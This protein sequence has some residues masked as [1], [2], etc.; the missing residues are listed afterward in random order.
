MVRTHQSQVVFWG[1][2]LNKMGLLLCFRCAADRYWLV[3]VGGRGGEGVDPSHRSLSSQEPAPGRL[4][5]VCS[6]VPSADPFC[7]FNVLS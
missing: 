7:D 6:E 5:V 1:G 2:G 3:Q 4:W